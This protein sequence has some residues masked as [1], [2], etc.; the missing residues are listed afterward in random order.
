MKEFK[1]VGSVCLTAL[2]ALSFLSCSTGQGGQTGAEVTV[3]LSSDR[4]S[5]LADNTT[6]ATFTVVDNS[7][8]TDVTAQSVIYLSSADI[9]T[10]NQERRVETACPVESRELRDFLCGYLERILADDAQARRLL[11][12]GSYTPA[13]GGQASVQS[14]YLEHPIRLAPTRTPSGSSWLERLLRRKT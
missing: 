8:S 7:T 6:A 2:I 1:S 9:M 3:S 14:Y 5:I 4:S 10:R 11:P 13:G 12:D